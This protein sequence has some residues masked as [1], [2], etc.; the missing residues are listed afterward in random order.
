MDRIIYNNVEE[1]KTIPE[2]EDRQGYV[3]V[4]DNGEHIKIGWST[5]VYQRMI[6][7]SHSNTGGNEIK[8]IYLSPMSAIYNT[9]EY[10]MHQTFRDYR[11]VGE[12]FTGIS[13][14]EVCSQLDDFCKSDS[15]IRCNEVRKQYNKKDIRDLNEFSK[16]PHGFC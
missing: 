2:C 4:I 5:N 3:Y 10:S 14:E 13:F 9:L 7:L 16:L 1:L 8:R 12:W 15:Y 6:S 11:T